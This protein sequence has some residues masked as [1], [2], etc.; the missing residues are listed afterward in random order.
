MN[1]FEKTLNKASDL[2]K[3]LYSAA[4][5]IDNKKTSSLMFNSSAMIDC[6]IKLVKAYE[7]N[8]SSALKLYVEMN[9]ELKDYAYKWTL[10]ATVLDKKTA[11]AIKI[12][13][14]S[15]KDTGNDSERTDCGTFNS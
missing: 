2:S 13:A 11:E 5:N 10:A 6:L 7:K 12:L 14:N 8:T 1:D 15:R 3:S 4:R 9:R